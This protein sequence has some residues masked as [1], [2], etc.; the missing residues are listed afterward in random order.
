VPYYFFFALF[1]GAPLILVASLVVV[2][3]TLKNRRASSIRLTSR[4]GFILCLTAIIVSTWTA[5]VYRDLVRV[6]WFDLHMSRWRLVVNLLLPKVGNSVFGALM[7]LWL[8]G[9]AR[10]I[11]SRLDRLGYVLGV[12][13]VVLV[14]LEDVRW[15]LE[16]VWLM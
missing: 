10:P 16:S 12:V 5:V 14:V 13:W 8:A 15:I 9:R 2:V 3:F 7:V 1:N 6:P 11:A 4:P